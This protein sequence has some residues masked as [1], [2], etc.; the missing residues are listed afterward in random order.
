MYIH[1]YLI[2]YPAG[3]PRKSTACPL[4]MATPSPRV[5]LSAPTP[6]CMAAG[7]QGCC[8]C[9]ADAVD[10]GGSATVC[11]TAEQAF[12]RGWRG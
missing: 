10:A 6:R 11:S 4:S 8:C 1:I 5:H 12:Q 9:A 7:C 3:G 2:V